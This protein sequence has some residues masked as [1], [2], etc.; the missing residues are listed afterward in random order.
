M[1]SSFRPFTVIKLFFPLCSVPPFEIMQ[2]LTFKVDSGSFTP[3]TRVSYC[4]AAH[5]RGASAYLD[6]PEHCPQC[7]ILLLRDFETHLSVL[8]FAQTSPLE[9]AL[10][11]RDHLVNIPTTA[12]SVEKKGGFRKNALPISVFR[13]IHGQLN[14]QA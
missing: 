10:H 11:K 4:I 1:T 13:W 9:A 5:H 8:L 7:L 6:E 12:T 3:G 2:R 14:A